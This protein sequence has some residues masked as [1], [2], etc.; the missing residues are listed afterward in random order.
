MEKAKYDKLMEKFNEMSFHDGHIIKVKKTDKSFKIAF[1]DGWMDELTNELEFTEY[2]TNNKY[3][4]NDRIIYQLMNIDAQP[5]NSTKDIFLFEMLVWHD[6]NLCEVVKVEAMNVIARQYEDGKL[7]S[8][9]DFA[10]GI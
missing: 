7:I 9:I 1:T 3:D 8:E 5:Y 10:K 4:L 2:R 6:D